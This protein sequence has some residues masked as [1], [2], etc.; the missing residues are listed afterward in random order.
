MSF[1]EEM[2][3]LLAQMSGHDRVITVPK[4]YVE[5][6]GD[7]AEAILLNQIVFYSDK[8]KRT[9]GFFYKTHRDWTEEVCLTERQIRHATKKL[10]EKKLIETK[11]LKANGAP[12]THYKLLSDNLVKWITTL[13]GNGK[14]QNVVIDYD[15]MSQSLTEIT[16]EITTENNNNEDAHK[17]VESAFKF[18]EQNGFGILTPH[19][20]DKIGAWIDDTNEG[21]VIYALQIAVE[22]SALRW[23]YA[24]SILRDWSNKKYISVDQVIAAES[25]R[26]AGRERNAGIRKPTQHP[27]GDYDGID[28]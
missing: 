13:C 22:N 27:N 25:K 9:D 4:I 5:L 23:N 16:T 7:L 11:V 19:V 18:F 21:L 15:I 28:F 3:R 1:Y 17:P 12:T 26:T 10:K 8:S 6:T 20:A 24:E 2:R 14:Q